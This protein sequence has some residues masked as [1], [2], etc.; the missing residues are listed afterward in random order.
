MLRPMSTIHFI[1]GEKG[2]VGKS[3]V[4]RLAAQYC[5]DKRIPFMAADADGSHG[6]LVRFYSD[7]AR[8]VD[9]SD[10]D[11]VDQI[12]GLA[13][14][15]DRRV[16]VDLPAQADRLVAA[17]VGEAGI[18]E[19]AAEAGVKIVFWHVIDDGKD[20]LATLDR[21]LGRYGDRARYCVVKNAGRGAFFKL[22]DES[23]VRE[24]AE[25]LGAA[26]FELAELNPAV[27]QKIDR[28]D[29]SFWAAAQ[30]T[31]VGSE[32]FTRIERQRVKVWLTAAYEELAKL[33][34]LF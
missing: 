24:A 10:T 18:L 6:A 3:V 16:L 32:S 17:W 34:D 7:Y 33:G 27:M 13:T 12:L 22:F 28:L 2:G 30:G 5:I 8:P 31:T 11:S 14:E 20:A 25:R 19:L 1:G 15:S 23:P 9:L 29:A 4:A 26:I 21:L